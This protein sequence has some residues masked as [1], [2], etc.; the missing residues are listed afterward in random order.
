MKSPI[1]CTALDNNPG[2][3]IPQS[4]NRQMMSTVKV[5][6]S[7]IDSIV[8]QTK[9]LVF[10]KPHVIHRLFDP[11]QAQIIILGRSKYFPYSCHQL[12]L[13]NKDYA[14]KLKIKFLMIIY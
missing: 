14:E 12:K 1:S 4:A 5:N 10:L 3:I 6:V 13:Q 11:C 7:K 9:G 8:V 2:M